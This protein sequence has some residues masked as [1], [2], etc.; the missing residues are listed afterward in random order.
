MLV[1]ILISIFIPVFSDTFYVSRGGDDNNTG[2]SWNTSFLT[3]TKAMDSVTS[4]DIVWVEEGTY[5]E[6]S[7]IK[8]S[9]GVKVYGGFA[10]NETDLSQRNSSIYKT[11]ID[12]NNDHRCVYNYGVL[13]G[14][15]ITRGLSTSYTS[16]G[17][18]NNGILQ[19]SEIY[20]NH[21]DH[22]GGIDNNGS[23]I[24][25][26][27]YNNHATNNGGG[28]INSSS[29]GLIL[30]CLIYG[31]SAYN[32]GGIYSE[33]SSDKIVNCVVYGN[34]ADKH[35][36][37]SVSRDSKIH[38]C[39]SWGNDTGD[40]EGNLENVSYC[41]FGQADGSNNNFR[42]NPLFVR[43]WGDLSRWDFNLQ[44][45]SPCIDAGSP[46]LATETDILGKPR[47]GSDGKVCMGAYESPDDYQK[48]APLP[49]VRLYVSKD[50]SDSGG[51]SWD[52]AFTSIT[53]CLE[54]TGD[55]LYEIWVAGGLYQEG[56]RIGVP[57]RAGLFGGFTGTEDDLSLRNF[58][59]NRTIIDGQN[60]HGCI[61]NGGILDGFIV[62]SGKCEDDGIGIYNGGGL[63]NHCEIHSNRLIDPWYNSNGGGVYNY[64]GRIKNSYI[65]NNMISGDGGGIYN[66]FGVVENCVIYRN[67]AEYGGGVYNN[68]G[69]LYH[70]SIYDNYADNYADLDKGDGIYNRN[71]IYNCIVWGNN[72]FDISGS[73][74]EVYNSCFGQALENNGN[75]RANPL[76]V[77][78]S[79]GSEGWDFRI[80]NGSPCI[81]KGM[82]LDFIERDMED[83]DRPGADGKVCMGAYESPDE[84]EPA[85]PVVKRI[86]VSKSG[87]NTTGN[88][89][90]EAYTEIASALENMSGDDA[91]EI[92]VAEGNYPESEISIPGRVALYGGFSGT[93]ENLSERDFNLHHSVIDGA[94]DNIGV[95]NSGILDGLH[96]TKCSGMRRGGGILNQFGIVNNCDVYYNS[97]WYKG[98]GICNEEGIIKNT[99]VHEN[100]VRTS[101]YDSGQG[102]GIYNNSG[103]VINCE[104]FGNFS[105]TEKGGGIYNDHG[106]LRNCIIYKNNAGTQGGGVYNYSGNIYNCTIYRNMA[107]SKGG[108]VYLYGWIDTGHVLVKNCIIWN[109]IN[110]DLYGF[111]KH[112]FHS[113]FR[114][115][116]GNHNISGNPLFADTS[117]DMFNWDFHLQNGSPCI[118]AGSMEGA[119]P[120]DSEGNPRP[121]DDGYVCMGAYESQSDFEPSPPQQVKRIFVSKSGNDSSGTSWD[122]AF[123]NIK[124]AINAAGDNLFEIWVAQATYREGEE[125]VIPMGSSLYGGF[126]GNET[127]LSQRDVENAKTVIDGN[128]SHRCVRNNG[129]LNGFHVI[130]GK[131]IDHGDSEYNK[132]AGVYNTGTMIKCRIYN[133]VYEFE[134]PYYVKNKVKQLLLIPR[135]GGGVFN[136]G[137]LI[138][139]CSIYGNSARGLD[140]YSLQ[141]GGVLNIDDGIIQD[142]NVNDNFG[143]WSGGGI[144]NIEG[145]VLRCSIYN[146]TSNEG[147]GIYNVDVLQECTVYNNHL[148]KNNATG[149]GVYNT[150]GDIIDC[151]IYENDA[152]DYKGG[153][154]YNYSGDISGC[155]IYGNHAW[156]GAG[157]YHVRGDIIKC[158][159]FQ[160][161]SENSGGG[162]YSSSRNNDDLTSGCSIFSNSAKENGGGVYLNKGIIRNSCFFNNNASD[163]GGGIFNASGWIDYCTFVKNSAASDGGGIYNNLNTT[164]ISNTVSWA[165]NQGDISGERS[166]VSY[167][168][169]GGASDMNHNIT[170][171]PMFINIEGEPGTWNLR[172]RD[173]SPCIDAANVEESPQTDIEGNV[174]P[175]EDGKTCMGSFES[176]PEY[177]PGPPP[178]PTR[179]YVSK[180]G[181]NTDGQSWENAF[182]DLKTAI[183]G[184]TGYNCYEIWVAK[185][186]YQEDGIIEIPRLVMMYGGF[187]GTEVNRDDRDVKV[188]QCIINGSGSHRCVDNYGYL[189][190]FYITNGKSSG[191]GGGVMNY[192][193][194]VKSCHIYG[195][196]AD[197]L[198]G[199][200][201]NH[202]LGLVTSCRIYSNYA[203]FYAGGI[204]N[205]A[206]GVIEDGVVYDNIADRQ[207]GGIFNDGGTLTNCIIYGNSTSSLETFSRGGGIYSENGGLVK[208]CSI[209]NNVTKAYGGG[210]YISEGR[211]ENSLIYNNQANE[212]SG[213]GICNEAS[214]V[215]NCTV[216]GNEAGRDG[217]G[218]YNESFGPGSVVKNSIIW[219]NS[220]EDISRNFKNVYHSCFA[221]I[222]IMN[223][224]S[225]NIMSAPVFKNISGDPLT[226]DLHLQ[227]GSPGIDGGDHEDAPKEDIE[228]KTRPG[229]DG[230]ICMGA[231]E[232]P[233]EYEPGEEP[234][235]ARLYVSKN[236][237]NSNGSSWATAFTDIK[238][239]LL[240]VSGNRMNEIWVAEGVYQEGEE[241]IS[242]WNVMMYGGFSG[243]ES[244]LSER[245]P[246]AHVT[247]IKGSESHRCIRNSG[248]MDGFSVTKGYHED[249]GGGIHNI[250]GIVKNCR[251]YDNSAEL[252]G[253]GIENKAGIIENCE[254]YQNTA[255]DIDWSNGGGIYN[256]RNGIVSGCEIYLN[257]TKNRAGGIYNYEGSIIN[258]L[259]YKN[260]ADYYCGGIY[261]Y[262]YTD[263]DNDDGEKSSVI[264]CT[265][266]G[267]SQGGLRNNDDGVAL[268]CIIWNNT[269]FD[270]SG[271]MEYVTNS[272]F[273]EASDYNENISANPEFVNGEGEVSGLDFHLSED[274]RCIDAATWEGAP[275]TGLDGNSRPQGSGYDMGAYEYPLPE[276]AE[277]IAQNAPSVLA[278]G[279]TREVRIKM[280]NLGSVAWTDASGH[281]L[282]DVAT[283]ETIWGV[284]RVNLD[285]AKPVEQ[286]ELT[287]FTFTVTAPDLPGVYDFQWRMIREP[288]G[289]WFGEKSDLLKIEVFL[290]GDLN[291]DG[292]L[293]LE[294]CHLLQHLILG[295]TPVTPEVR[296]QADMNSDG[297][298]SVCDIICILANLE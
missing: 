241:L 66:D 82:I 198:G 209:Y 239:A 269:G 184:I 225:G 271:D 98:G 185:G 156:R 88:S 119:P 124:T 17:V 218:I 161:I 144:S 284:S 221:S 102:G 127:E 279:E 196:E 165:N 8:I 171:D 135:G 217:G 163:R 157:I 272:C 288:E 260:T 266:S 93:E 143:E 178:A 145:T 158:I 214:S 131:L 12:G 142:C 153:G 103:Q 159:L 151:V 160:N 86:Y 83:N 29:K 207:G 136:I 216:Y 234:Q 116:E 68:D 213:G 259:V 28:I 32:G 267:N 235:P 101:G 78:I 283:T 50:G 280:K 188:N 42:A 9:Y 10:G 26:R 30:N 194:T 215:I 293:T 195:N 242:P 290:I 125:I 181:N 128:N 113:C 227:N 155:M 173:G 77:N 70:L 140:S 254:I 223:D 229:G 57:G 297:G 180:S 175:G 298:L 244:S 130:N 203:P 60:K 108:G 117:G 219:N 197:S 183:S 118:D 212:N 147:G 4:G 100:V 61:Y 51:R 2:Q 24:N 230:K 53:T 168:C 252:T 174:R 134:Y 109:N 59:E 40:I 112:V 120:E 7:V 139:D 43:T 11:I 256:W 247:V 275:E 36:G 154:I 19:N 176:P 248:L 240:N 81:D 285:A 162:I 38:N 87:D 85:D 107:N 201:Y 191:N 253:A 205:E 286:N 273:S 245:T 148:E 296:F 133:N 274:S 106:E 150:N 204:Y 55:D 291:N 263:D 1:L 262:N 169:F 56:H 33:Y 99:S 164:R 186:E 265:V 246:E 95:V 62:T 114:G 20:D 45:G 243:T 224:E 276:L 41:C 222:L 25:C 141:G 5:L 270:L 287:S 91:Y 90:E 47:P 179:I 177:E 27:I 228:G 37:I 92:W 277:F 122:T 23:I 49:P 65:Y 15:S 64:G 190:G 94:F 172:L 63:V 69:I 294:D 111:Q 71:E 54:L 289:K 84:Y 236:G 35:G 189:D 80:Q 149:A 146:N 200:L 73:A 226:W 67:E 39:I 238:T 250:S 137:G 170:S 96:I 22:G 115:A 231:Y 52:D 126:V 72:K 16:G 44:D 292:L 182:T 193:G 21:S 110:N 14:F 258:C 46:E 255:L 232:S 268:N 129:L 6:G 257:E 74:E 97:S 278:P 199:G 75:I 210:V 220:N 211:I 31:N 264:N 105:D 249:W 89:W 187:L 58:R 76:F 237:D 282:G 132:G 152:G 13:D 206:E 104:I 192:S 138:S 233:D 3:L 34:S 202:S 18:N 79:G 261:N 166:S 48:G 121:G 208:G 295:R 251:V 167:S 123:R 281:Q